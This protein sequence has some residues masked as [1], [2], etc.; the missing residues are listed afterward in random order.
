MMFKNILVP[1]DLTENSRKAMNI[2]LDMVS[3]E[4]GARITLL[5]V[6]ETIEDADEKEFGEFYDRLMKRAQEG[7]ARLID[8]LE[9]VSGYFDR[10][11]LFGKRVREIVNFAS[12]N[13]VDLIIVSSHRIDRADMTQ[14]W[15]TI[16]YK[17]GILSHC[18][19]LMVK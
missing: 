11:I 5:H 9:E 6:I 3:R 17:V 12:E 10:K 8:P 1:T 2:A 19:V 18:P 4:K 7:M 13:S 14:G 16:S 15:A